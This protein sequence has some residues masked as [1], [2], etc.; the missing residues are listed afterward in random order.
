LPGC[1]EILY[2]QF[3]GKRV[4]VDTWV[5]ALEKNKTFLFECGAYMTDL[6]DKNNDAIIVGQRL[7]RNEL[8]TSVTTSHSRV[9]HFIKATREKARYGSC[10]LEERGKT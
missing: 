10:S 3:I 4:F 8:L 5:G 9:G 1:P 7:S 2:S 6:V